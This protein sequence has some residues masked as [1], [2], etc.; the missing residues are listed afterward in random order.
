MTHDIAV[1]ALRRAAN[2]NSFVRACEEIVRNAKHVKIDDKAL[3]AYADS[4]R[5]P[6]FIPDWHDYL[7]DRIV[8]RGNGQYIQD[9]DTRMRAALFELAQNCSINGGYT[10]KGADGKTE[11]W[12]KDGS[13]AAALLH[14]LKTLW[15]HAA[16]PG[17]TQHDPDVANAVMKKL[18]QDVPEQAFRDERIS[19]LAAFAERSA[20]GYINYG[21][22][23]AKRSPDH[24]VFD[25]R[26]TMTLGESNVLAFH[27]DPF[28]KK[29]LLLP[30]LFASYA[31][32]EG[33]TVELDLPIPSD[34][35]VPQTLHN[36]GVLRLSKVLAREINSGKLFTQDE[37][38]V[39]ELRAAS[40]VA[41]DRILERARARLAQEHPGFRL[42]INHLDADMWFAGR[43]FDKPADALDEKKQRIRT[44]LESFGKKSGFREPGFKARADQ[45]INVHTL[46]F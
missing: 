18:L 21:Y 34:Y 26:T 9:K 13:G 11:K 17:V 39:T 29:I 19:L 12:Q 20:V 24:F 30:V 45:A 36:I 10:Y 16:V 33:V 25:Y 42:E 41:V 4:L 14:S 1:R 40:V 38:A 35:R 32:S 37:A 15:A 2:K 28:R 46:R 22:G 27:E 31:Q 44:E 5:K 43:L 3:T 7:S 23:L 8:D 6:S